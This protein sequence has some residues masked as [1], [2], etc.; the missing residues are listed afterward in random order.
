[1]PDPLEGAAPSVDPDRAQRTALPGRGDRDDRLA[2]VDQPVPPGGRDAIEHRART[3]VQDGGA[4]VPGDRRGVMS[5][6]EYPRQ[7]PHQIRIGNP[8]VDLPTRDAQ[9]LQ[10]QPAH[11]AELPVRAPS[12]AFFAAAYTH[13]V[14]RATKKENSPPSLARNR[15]GSVPR[16]EPAAASPARERP[17]PEPATAPPAGSP[18][19]SCAVSV[20]S[21]SRSRPVSS[22]VAGA[23]SM[24]C[25][26]TWMSRKRRWS[27]L[28]S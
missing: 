22:H 11:P 6:R 24:C 17:R 21:P 27:G 15:P 1:M 13:C 25:V 7:H 19:Y 12:N 18:S 5:D 23:M 9:T 8:P 10:L 28:V 26:A 3:G 2:I 4:Q 14:Y 20:A 16:P